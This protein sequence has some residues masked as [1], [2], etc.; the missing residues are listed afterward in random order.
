M[1]HDV[2]EIEAG[3]APLHPNLNFSNKK[4]KE[5]KAV[6]ILKNQLP[7]PLNNKFVKLFHEFE[8]LKTPES[9][10]V[11]TCAKAEIKVEISS[12]AKTEKQN[13]VATEKERIK[14]KAQKAFDEFD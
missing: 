7:A 13:I 3:D 14:Q 4:E 1:Y 2:I 12:K 6:E 9:K 10:F 5:E 8:E 11:F